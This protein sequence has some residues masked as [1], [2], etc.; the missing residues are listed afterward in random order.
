[1]V[2]GR[3]V[4][5]RVNKFINSTTCSGKSRIQLGRVC[6]GQATRQFGDGAAQDANDQSHC[7]RRRVPGPSIKEVELRQGW[8]RPGSAPHF[9]RRIAQHVAG[10]RI[11]Y[12][13]GML[14]NR[15]WRLSSTC[16]HT[17]NK[18]SEW[19]F[20]RAGLSDLFKASPHALRRQ[21]SPWCR[22]VVGSARARPTPSLG[23]RPLPAAALPPSGGERRGRTKR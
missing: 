12:Y 11:S 16:M 19:R 5:G 17:G 18:K 7:G 14:S 15:N 3:M 22:T 2:A 13:K 20:L 10:V 21:P 1:L 23:S 9:P 8:Q 6:L 4:S